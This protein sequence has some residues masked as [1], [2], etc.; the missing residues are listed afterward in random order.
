MGRIST[1]ESYF[2]LLPLGNFGVLVRSLVCLKPLEILHSVT[3]ANFLPEQ[4]CCASRTLR[5]AHY[6]GRQGRSLQGAGPGVCTVLRLVV[7][8]MGSNN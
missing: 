5:H 4:N 2:A 3:D 1:W 8:Y 7:D 6:L